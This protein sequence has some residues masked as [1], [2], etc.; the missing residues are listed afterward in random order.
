MI[1]EPLSVGGE[2]DHVPLPCNLRKNF[3]FSDYIKIL[4]KKDVLCIYFFRFLSYLLQAEISH[5][6]DICTCSQSA[7]Q[8]LQQCDLHGSS[9]VVF[10][11]TISRSKVKGYSKPSPL[12]SLGFLLLPSPP[13]FSG[14][15]KT[16]RSFPEECK[17]LLLHNRHVWMEKGK[18]RREEWTLSKLVF[19]TETGG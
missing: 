18:V 6:N 12:I 10:L 9:C 15:F 3:T 4:I 1:D 8:N 13:L 2:A 11:S 14:P 19:I 17:S 5:R 16:S 7:R